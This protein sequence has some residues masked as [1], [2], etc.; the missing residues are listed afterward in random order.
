MNAM[1][2][3]AL[4]LYLYCTFPVFNGIILFIILFLHSI[5]A[6][7]TFLVSPIID[8]FHLYKGKIKLSRKFTDIH[9][10]VYNNLFT[11]SHTQPKP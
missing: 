8:A 3:I 2:P 7:T 1:Q 11:I 6:T 5:S 4:L 9:T 10:H